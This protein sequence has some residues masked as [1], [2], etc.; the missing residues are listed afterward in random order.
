[1]ATSNAI[2]KREENIFHSTNRS[3]KY[4]TDIMNH[5]LST[6]KFHLHY[7]LRYRSVQFWFYARRLQSPKDLKSQEWDMF[8]SNIER[9][10]KST[11]N[12]STFYKAILDLSIQI[13]LLEL[14]GSGSQQ[15]TG[16][17]RG[18]LG[19]G[20]GRALKTALAMYH[21]IKLQNRCPIPVSLWDRDVGAKLSIVNKTRERDLVPSS[22]VKKSVVWIYRDRYLSC[23]M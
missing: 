17:G 11:S 4:N 5:K 7:K 18:S 10:E 6:I 16:C 8:F 9:K 13:C 15:W 14:Q 21:T 1:M 12:L 3:R 20:C 2:E 19:T 23:E 22:L